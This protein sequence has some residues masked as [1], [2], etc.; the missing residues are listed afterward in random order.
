MNPH[1]TMFFFLFNLLTISSFS[2]SQPSYKD[3]CSSVIAESTP[4]DLVIHNSFPRGGFCTGG[5]GIIHPENSFN[6]YS[7]FNLR[8]IKLHET[9]NYDL[10]KIESTVSFSNPNTV[11]Y[12]VSNFSY[13]NKPSYKIQRHF[14]TNFVTFKLQG[15]WSKSSG[16]VCMVG[17]GIGYSKTGDS[18]N[19]V[20]V[21]KLNNVFNSS[22]VTSLV[23]GSLESLSSEKGD[24]KDHYFEAISLIMLLE[25]NY[26][27]SLDSKEVENE[28]SFESDVSQNS[29][30]LN[31]YSS[32][33]CKYPLA[34][35]IRRLQLEYTH[36][37][38]SSKNC[39]P[40]ISDQLPYMM[41]LKGVD[42][43]HTDKHRFKV[44]MVFS[45]KSDYW[46]EKGFNPKTW[47]I[48][49]GWWNEKEN[50]FCVVA[51]HF[52][53]ILKSSLNGSRVGDC[54][55]RLRLRFPSV[56]STKNTN[57]I[58]G[59]IWSNKSANDPNYFKMITFRNF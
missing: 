47:L 57:S 40:I 8:H 9:I 50:S 7:H 43:S 33:F 37:C 5:S 45:N 29:L 25:E 30:S 36:E 24:E 3:H 41:S 28:F 51:C 18:L 38:N 19:L 48:G 34:S 35:A 56:W 23:T 17:T 10:F 13:G 49:E 59:H 52:I 26:S 55:V 54:S 27:Y 11:Y 32:S 58:I 15:F 12:H 4:K 6:K 42:C 14:R 44:V 22:I 21:F 31:P 53:G 39:T 1:L 46:I 2:S 16:K 20:A